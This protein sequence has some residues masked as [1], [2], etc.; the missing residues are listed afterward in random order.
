[1]WNSPVLPGFIDTHQHPP[2]VGNAVSGTCTL[3]RNRNLDSTNY[4]N[5]LATCWQGKSDGNGSCLNSFA[6]VI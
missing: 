3:A 2:E 5:K 6:L 4:N 1:M